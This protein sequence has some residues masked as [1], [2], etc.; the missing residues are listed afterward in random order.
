MISMTK[1]FITLNQVKKS[2]KF[3][4]LEDFSELGKGSNAIA[5]KAVHKITKQYVVIKIYAIFEEDIE[6]RKEK[7][8]HEIQKNVAFRLTKNQEVIFEIR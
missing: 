7:C 2:S 1:H 8:F 5:F 6:S 4:N 3:S